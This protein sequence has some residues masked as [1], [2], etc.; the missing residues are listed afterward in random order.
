MPPSYFHLW[1]YFISK[2]YH[3]H[4]LADH[5]RFSWVPSLS[6]SLSVNPSVFAH[7]SYLFHTLFP[8]QI[9]KLSF[10][11][12]HFC[13]DDRDTEIYLVN[14]V[15]CIALI[16]SFQFCPASLHRGTLHSS[17]SEAW[18]WTSL[19]PNSTA[20]SIRVDLVEARLCGVWLYTSGQGF[21]G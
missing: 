17:S 10:T 15:Y 1:S 18:R 5:K 4:F 12:K 3:L 13:N 21:W 8:F 19:E 7:V 20:H 2:Q 11:Q 16:G 6:H 14:G 9:M